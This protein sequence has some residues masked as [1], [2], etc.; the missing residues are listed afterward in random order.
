M[1]FLYDCRRRAFGEEKSVP[2]IV[3]SRRVRPCDDRVKLS[4]SNH[5][6]QRFA[7]I[8]GQQN[9]WQHR[10]EPCEKFPPS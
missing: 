9:I 6:D 8:E 2:T 7:T 1:E 3:L 5:F 4:L 10:L